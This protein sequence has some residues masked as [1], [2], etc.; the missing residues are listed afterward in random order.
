[1]AE[2]AT[3]SLIPTAY[4]DSTDPTKQK[5][6]PAT[7]LPV[8]DATAAQPAQDSSTQLPPQQDANQ[9][10][11][12]TPQA[13]S[14]AAA[15]PTAS[16][17][18]EQTT[19]EL[20][21]AVLKAAQITSLNQQQN[22]L[23]AAVDAQTAKFVNDP[24]LGF[25][26]AKYNQS[27]LEQ[28]DQNNA[29]AAE[30]ARQQ[31]ASTSQSGELQ[32]DFL[33]TVLSNQQARGKQASDLDYAAQ[34]AKQANLIAALNEGRTTSA[35]DTASTTGAINNMLNTRAAGEG[36]RSQ[37][38]GFQDDVALTNLGFD[39]TTQL[40]AQQQGYDLTKLN[41]TY[42]LE[43]TKAAVQHGYDLDS[44]T[45]QFG[46]DMTK[47]IATQD[48]S[49]AQAQLDR[50]AAVAAQS[51]NIDAQKAAQ[52]KQNAFDLQK[53]NITQ[54]WQSAQNKI[55][56]DFQ[57]AAQKND[58]NATAANI[59]KQLDLEKWKQENGQTFTAEQNQINNAL[60]VS[61]KSM[62]IQGQKD[63]MD[64]KGKIDTGMM[65]TQE[66]FTASQSSLDRAEKDALQ[67]GDIQGQLQIQAQKAVID[68]QAQTAQNEFTK[69]ITAATQS[70]QT[71]E[72]I[73]TED[74]NKQMQALDIANKQAMQAND[75]DTQKYIQG[76]QANL[77]LQLQTQD[78][79]QQEKM[80]YVN[81]QIAEAKANGDNMR[82]MELIDFTTRQDLTKI[83]TTQGY[84]Q[85]NM[86]LQG[87]IDTAVKNNDAANVMAL[88]KV[89]Q[90]FQAQEH[91]KD[92][93]MDQLKIGLEGKQIEIA[94]KQMTFDE[95]EAGVAAG[96]IA[97]DAAQ[98]AIQSAATQY[99]ITV[100]QPDPQ[101]AQKKIDA[102][103]TLQLHQYGLTHPGSVVTDAKGNEVLAQSA[104]QDFNDFQNKT[105]YGTDGSG[106]DA[107]AKLESGD[108]SISTL[109]GQ[110]DTDK[111]KA[112]LAAAAEFDYKG[113]DSTNKNF[114]NAPPATNSM[115]NVNGNL[116]Q[117]QSE[118][119]RAE[120]D[121]FVWVKDANTGIIEKMYAGR[122]IVS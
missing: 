77:Q 91:D 37:T 92:L 106:P 108:V 116:Y 10:V 114:I 54:D 69:Q 64:L 71:G 90:S 67:K 32:N 101:A 44:M 1:M 33:K 56:Q 122:G 27:Q 107:L 95:I 8:Q 97:P 43:A 34:Q 41:A 96:Q 2:A 80:A 63:L 7:G 118:K 42:G 104:V 53:L 14:N 102:D 61:L 15:T 46:L 89:Q 59:Q 113:T 51:K 120:G 24:N 23:N 112:V 45:K 78:M 26:Y 70:W 4:T 85:A 119:G 94:N 55:A 13:Y 84:T 82:Q 87:R 22:P 50:D 72:R 36:E 109:R 12:L 60:Q 76:Q 38:Q 17:A 48:W 18:P 29:K 11:A 105:I 52:D 16:T 30:A 66:D 65:L 25:D 6:D 57:A 86:E 99:G 40:A 100:Q 5:I 68:Q 21:D 79:N 111:Y 83:A 73:G 58:I 35:S 81:S 103:F 3:S 93:V 74:A 28:T 19:A 117:V 62:D 121:E 39:H 115:I 88:T 98:A 47:M 20:N 75:I 49:G 110:E 31:L 9:T